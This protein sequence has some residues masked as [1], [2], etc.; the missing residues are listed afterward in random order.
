MKET[1]IAALF[2]E[3]NRAVQTGD[4]GRVADLY[5]PDSILLPTLSNRVRRSREDIMDYFDHFLAKGPSGRIDES[6]I[7]IFGEIAV[8]SGIY[9]F[10]FRDGSS[11][12][13]RFTFVYKWDGERWM[14]ME[15]HSSL[16]PEQTE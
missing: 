5:A 10:T 14:I 13:A 1:E 7:R 16:M 9:T 3:W 11:A 15:H 12:P 2:D 4:S 8:N 6:D